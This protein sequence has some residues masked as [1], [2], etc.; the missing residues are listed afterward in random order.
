MHSRTFVLSVTFSLLSFTLNQQVLAEKS[1]RATR[2]FRPII[3]IRQSVSPDEDQ[4]IARTVKLT[5]PTTPA[6]SSA[7]FPEGSVPEVNLPPEPASSD[8]A[9][10]PGDQNPS[11]DS[12]LKEI[13]PDAPTLAKLREEAHR[14]AD[15]GLTYRFGADDPASGG[16]DCSG[17]MQ[18]LLSKIGVEDVP[19]TSYDQ[20]YWLKRKKL[21]DDVFGKSASSKMLKKLTPGD[22]I[23]WGGT[24]KS[25]HRVSHV[26]LYLGYDPSADK[27]YIFGARGKSSKGML[28][29]GVDI[30]E[31]DP[32]RGRLIAHGKI[33]G[34]QY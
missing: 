21:L 1:D 10:S 3:P 5:I 8:E 27:H 13:D 22:L 34:L 15:R 32:D 18:Y 25:G 9:D 17:A 26:M 11:E 16:L 31:L 6:P 29:N 30:F 28:G 4:A 24:W 20:Y 12:S 23:F 19:R 2:S 7:L 14:L 33:P